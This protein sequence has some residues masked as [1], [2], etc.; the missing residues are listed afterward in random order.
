MRG[1]ELLEDAFER[2]S[3]KRVVALGFGHVDRVEVP[4]VRAM[5]AIR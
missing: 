4:E 1:D 5:R 2:K 3:V